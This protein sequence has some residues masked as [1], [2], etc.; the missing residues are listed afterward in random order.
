MPVYFLAE[1]TRGTA[2]WRA[3]DEAPDVFLCSVEMTAYNSDSQ[4]RDRF[5]ELVSAV[6]DH[7]RCKH[8][9]E[10]CSAVR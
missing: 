4:V 1:G 6:S 7:C 3:S 8:V 10:V 9:A 5:A 2:V